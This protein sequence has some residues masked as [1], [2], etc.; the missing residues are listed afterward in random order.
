MT[1]IATTQFFSQDPIQNA[2]TNLRTIAENLTQRLLTLSSDPEASLDE[3]GKLQRAISGVFT[4][5]KHQPVTQP[6][7]Q[8]ESEPEPEAAE[9]SPQEPP[10]TRETQ[11]PE[12]QTARDVQAPQEEP[13][14]K[15]PV[16]EQSPEPSGKA[17]AAPVACGSPAPVKQN[18]PRGGIPNRYGPPRSSKPP[19]YMRRMMKRARRNGRKRK[20]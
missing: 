9:K 16:E 3:I 12:A 10:I 19:K 5:L 20:K 7:P 6:Q 1:T 2:T 13:T 11:E 15:T 8:P 4:T 14:A 18:P 17:S